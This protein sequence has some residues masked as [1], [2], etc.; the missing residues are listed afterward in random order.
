M[1]QKLEVLAKEYWWGV[2]GALGGNELHTTG[3]ESKEHERH[4]M[5]QFA[6]A[7][8]NLLGIQ[9]LGPRHKPTGS[10][11]PWPG[12][13]ICLFTVTWWSSYTLKCENHRLRSACTL[14][15]GCFSPFHF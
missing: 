6:A 9:R 12:P 8:G 13:T 3:E 7:P 4:R 15:D 1:F 5:E 11:T 2:G 10:E 14:P